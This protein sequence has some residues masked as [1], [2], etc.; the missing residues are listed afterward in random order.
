MAQRSVT[1]LY[2]ISE[3]LPSLPSLLF[4]LLVIAV[5]MS[6]AHGFSI[7]ELLLPLIVFSVYTVIPL[8]IGVKDWRL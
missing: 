2:V 4:F 5:G 1:K 7:G 3:C 8:S 6:S